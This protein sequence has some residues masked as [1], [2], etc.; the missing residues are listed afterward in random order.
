MKKLYIFIALFITFLTIFT[1][2]KSFNQNRVDINYKLSKVEIQ[3]IELKLVERGTLEASRFI[4]IKSNIISNRAKI[5]E[6]LNE[7]SFA[8]KGSIIARFDKK[9]F[10]DEM[11]KWEYKIK[12]ARANLIKAEKEI[13][14]LQTQSKDEVEKL[15]KAFELA[16]I[17]LDNSKNGKGF[18][19]FNELKQKV[20]QEI[21]SLK[22]ATEELKDY[23]SLYKNG[24]ISKRERDK[25]EDSLKA[26]EENLIIAQDRF[27][28][29]REY[30]WAREIK[31]QE[32]KIKEIE[33]SIENK[34]IEAKF[35]QEDKEAQLEKSKSLLLYYQNE[36]QKSKQDIKN[37]DIKA[38]ISGVVLYRDI[39][40]NGKRAKVEIGD[41]VWQNQSFIQ[42]PD[43]SKMLVRTKIREVDLRFIKKDLSV[44]VILD[45]YPD[46]VFTGKIEYI[47]TIAKQDKEEANIKFFE[48]VVTLDNENEL[49]RSGMSARVEIIYN[50]L[51]D[52]VTIKN[53]A[54]HYEGG[55]TFVFLD[56]MVKKYIKVLNITDRYAVVE[57]LSKG[58]KILI[59]G[60]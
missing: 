56:E 5:V 32:I 22:L 12:I 25:V 10:I 17:N 27:N 19:K 13:E 11:K 54:L 38:T 39:P 21:R 20:A 51:K 31:E 8:T 55:K 14:I 18:I 47:D 28:N 58:D 4:Q 26:S 36:L 37:C 6:L 46:R 43:T 60:E 30:E 1:I 49:L 53:E 15:K 2:F 3:D 33:E 29:Y 52:A 40:K 48:T 35:K 23:E 24:Y 50:I 59:R 44:D 7:G 16:T 57:G 9:P 42:I 45:S 41:S 34:K